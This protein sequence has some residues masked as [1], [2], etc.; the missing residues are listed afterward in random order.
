MRWTGLAALLILAGLF[1]GRS[2][3]GP[4]S[5][6]RS[7][8]T[9]EVQVELF[10]EVPTAQLLDPGE[11]TPVDVY[12]EPAFGFVRLPVKYSQNGLPLDRSTPFVLR[13]KLQ[14]SLPAGD[15][16]FRLRTK[17]VARLTLDG[18]KLVES[19]PQKPNGD[20][21][22]PVPPPPPP[23]TSGIRPL[24]APHQELTV[25]VKLDGAPHQFTLVAVIGGKG[26]VP[27]PGELSVSFGKQGSTPRLLGLGETPLLTDAH[28]E[29]YVKLAQAR[30][31]TQDMVRRRA[32]GQPVAAAWSER[33]GKI[34]D[35]LRKQPVI[36]VPTV[37]AGMPALNP[38]DRFL[39]AKLKAAGKTPTALTSDLEF[40][41]RL[42][43]D[44]TGLIPT[45]ADL[46]RY[47]AD[48]AA[49][50]RAR[51]IDRYLAD[52]SWADHWVSYWQDVLAENP[53]ILKPDLNNSGPF[54]WWLHQAFTDNLPFDRLVTELVQ[55]QGS[56][57][58]GAPAGFA[59]ATLNDAPLAAKADILSQAFL[60]QNLSC[61]RCH[62]A[63][64]HPFRQQDLFALSAML[65]GKP[66]TI[67]E[68]STVHLVAG[69]RVPKVKV[70]TP[71][72]R[73]IPPGWPFPALAAGTQFLVP[74]SDSFVEPKHEVIRTRTELANLI[75]APENERFAQVLVNRV[76]KRLM[77]KGLVEPADDWSRAEPSNPELL[78]YLAREF[79]ASGYDLKQVTR[80]IVSSHA[81][82]RRP[83]TAPPEEL[84]PADRL[85]AGPYRRRLTAEQLVDSLF[86]AV[87][88][89]LNSEELNLNPLGDR[90]LTQFLNLG[91]PQRAWEFTA[92]SNERD[93]P[94]LALPV[95]QSISDVLTVYGWRQARQN[96]VTVRDD[97]PTPIQTL[98]L[99]NGV[100][101]TQV[102]RLSDDSAF[103]ELALENRPLNELIRELFLR[104]LSRSPSLKESQAFQEYLGASYA[105]RIVKGAAKRGSSA[106]SDRRV[107]WGNHLSE[108]ANAI[109]LAEERRLRLG[110]QPTGRLSPAFRERF[111]DVLWAVVNSSEFVVVP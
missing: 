79:V 74:G 102:V 95:A 3:A 38:I 19:G 81:Y 57:M 16:I 39:G 86:R 17:G 85:F 63:P 31:R 21:A 49:I 92:R 55:M 26:L 58:Q 46:H 89:P 106:G 35:W 103:T 110:D 69:F 47:L 10:E 43:L 82:Q 48:P 36:A 71:A 40:L 104:V 28:W 33:H 105:T 93:R 45:S 42:S 53:G 94:S 15:Y 56:A 30:H 52:P 20:G 25:P 60:A 27:D 107:S 22:D 70:T 12:A 99:A 75:V 87:G 83:M 37:P 101:G 91:A 108:E 44:T 32:L 96:P 4:P 8:D 88:R 2:E 59:Q 13:A 97:S 18:K 51:A 11:R 14:A 98:I 24:H 73:P 80:L 68:T 72:G 76:W 54:R 29:A 84:T 111:E 50:R 64:A 78:R 41:R 66:V 65:N 7:S 1:A 67:P 77:G 9:S 100:L 109:R 5:V 62:D 61:A 6:A 23:T 90:P 34:R